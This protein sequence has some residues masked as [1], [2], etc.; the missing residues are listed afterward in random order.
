MTEWKI[1]REIQQLDLRQTALENQLKRQPLA[2]ELK[3]L[4]AE[5]EAGQATLKKKVEAYEQEKKFLKQKEDEAAGQ[6][7]KIEALTKELYS[8]QADNVKE[9]AGAAARLDELKESLGMLD[10]EVISLMEKLEGQKQALMAETAELNAKKK[11][12]RQ[13]RQQYQA[14]KDE[15]SA[16]IEQIPTRQEALVKGVTPEII[17]LYQGL[18][19]KFPDGL[20]I[21]DTRNGICSGCHMGVS[22]DIIKQLKSDGKIIYCD[23]CG[24]ILLPEEQG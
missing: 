18:Q 23:H 14:K 2:K 24:R 3:E 16:E 22:F 15:I 21:A 20:V 11:R 13:L 4:K 19:G 8:G 1:L 10:D 9:L 17:A 12:F 7:E 5:I 6:E